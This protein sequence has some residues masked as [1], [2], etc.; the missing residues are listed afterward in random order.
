[1]GGFILQDT[2]IFSKA[3]YPFKLSNVTS[4]NFENM[5][6]FSE[7]QWAEEIVV[8]PLVAEYFIDGCSSGHMD[9]S[10]CCRN[11]IDLL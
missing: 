1:M 10:H 6:K 9:V 8:G 5:N 2:S 3:T 11:Q 7:C 4:N